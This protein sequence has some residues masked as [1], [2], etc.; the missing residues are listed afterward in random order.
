MRLKEKHVSDLSNIVNVVSKIRGV[1]GVFLFGSLARGDYDEYSDFDL[2]VIFEEKA[3]M[4]QNWDE[5]FQAVG[6]LKMI[7]HVIPQT[8][9]ELKAAN[10]VFLDELFRHGKVLFAKFPFEVFSRPVKLEPF[11]LIIYDMGGLSYRDKMKV[12]YFLYKKGG[13]GAVA[14][15]GGIK[16]T[17]GCVLV[18]SDVGDEIIDKLGAFGVDAKKLEIYVSEDHL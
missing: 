7:L 13:G 18:P 4:W 12:V 10:P 11:C 9:G 16:L 15:M 1:I 5:L 6:S 8:L 14:K 2:L 3:L 17:E